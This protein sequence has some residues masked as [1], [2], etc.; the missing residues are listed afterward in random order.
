MN[1]INYSEIKA[2]KIIL[3]RDSAND[4]E[5]TNRVKEI[6]SN[7]IKGG[8]ETLRK[9]TLSYDGIEIK[10]LKVSEDEINEALPQVSRQLKDAIKIAAGNISKFHKNQIRS[11]EKVETMDGV[12]CW[13]KSVPINIVGLYIPGGTAPLFST[14]LMLGI[15]AKLAG[16]KKIIICTPPGADGKIHPAILYT[17]NFLGLKEIYKVG[18]AQAVA[19]MAYGTET[20]PKAYKIFGPGNRYVTIAKQLVSLE[21]T[22]IDMPAGPSELAIIADNSANPE[23]VA[24][25]LLSQAEHGV[26]SQVLLICNDESFIDNVNKCIDCQL[27]QLPRK[28]IAIKSLERSYFVFVKDMTEA[29][30]LS[31]EYAP[32]HLIVSIKDVYNYL[33]RIENAGSVFIGNYSPE[34]A[35]DYASGTNHTLPTNGNAKAYS[36]VSID[37][38]V[39]N[40]TFQ[41]ISA[42]GIKNIGNTIEIMAENEELFAHKNA[43]TLRLK[44]IN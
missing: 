23:F 4:N 9:Y 17:A 35:G 40:I 28:E 29:F 22:A 7:V 11:E 27:E 32:E 39:K 5:I 44:E 6:I 2:G 8:D 25:D 31:N 24:S 13:R 38:F 10:D 43:V 30:D 41:D 37:S 15:P 20:I 36:G 3:K 12:V 42:S 26:D 14:L 1:K 19:A 21:N 34:S 16:C 18:G 33:D